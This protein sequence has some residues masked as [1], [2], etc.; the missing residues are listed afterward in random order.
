MLFQLAARGLRVCCCDAVSSAHEGLDAIGAA[1]TVGA[2]V[3][4]P[5]A[6]LDAD[7]D[8]AGGCWARA[9]MDKHE[10]RKNTNE[11]S[12][13]VTRRSLGKQRPAVGPVVFKA[14]SNAASAIIWSIVTARLSG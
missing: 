4:L 3:L 12:I 10:N 5:A 7:S 14:G 13:A 9:G 6:A 1:L 8:F 11:T 2:T